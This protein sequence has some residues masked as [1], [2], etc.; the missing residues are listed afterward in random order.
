MIN[1]INK[2][3]TRSEDE[4]VLIESSINSVRVNVVIKKF[5][6]LERLLVSIYTKFLMNRANKLNLLR[7]KPRPG[8]DLSFLI[9][10]FHLELYKKEEII[11]FIV[12][13]VQDFVK[14]ITDMKLT[15]NS[16][17]RFS[18]THLMEQIKV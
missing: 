14:E 5:S 1:E 13:F 17:S 6:D 9:T 3:I 11:D 16:Q 7:K 4:K 8:Y 10:N 15:V 2:L 12:G 18:S